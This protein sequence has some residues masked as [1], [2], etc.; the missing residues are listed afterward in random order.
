MAP[1][2][3]SWVVVLTCFHWG[4][5]A[6]VLWLTLGPTLWLW[7][8]YSQGQD[9]DITNCPEATVGS[10]TNHPQGVYYYIL[11]LCPKP[12]SYPVIPEIL[13]LLQLLLPLEPKSLWWSPD[14]KVPVP[15]EICTRLPALRHQATATASAPVPQNPGAVVAPCA[16]DPRAR[17]ALLTFWVPAF[18]TWCQEGFL[19]LELSSAGKKEQKNRRNPAACTSK[20]PN[21]PTH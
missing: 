13:L 20:D 1:P 14:T 10:L 16:P 4:R 15:Q 7:P 18:Q 12:P 2:R 8:N 5:P 11:P 9:A 21:S 17:A 6:A 3:Q 19:W